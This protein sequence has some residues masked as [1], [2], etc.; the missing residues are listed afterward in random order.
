VRSWPAYQGWEAH[1]RRPEQ[2]PPAGEAGAS[3]AP[4]GLFGFVYDIA[5]GQPDVM[6]LALGPLRQLA[7]LSLT[8]PPDVQ[9]FTDLGENAWTMTIYH[10]VVCKAGHI[11]LLKLACRQNIC[12][13]WCFYKR[14]FVPISMT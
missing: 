11:G 5:P 3:S 12:S 14:H 4:E 2:G 9:G 10:R 8:P 1:G 7:P 6:Q 13:L